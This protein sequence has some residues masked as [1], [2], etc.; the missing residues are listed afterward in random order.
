MQ[1]KPD[2]PLQKLKLINI[3]LIHNYTD[4]RFFKK[5]EEIVSSSHYGDVLYRVLGRSLK[6]W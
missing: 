5:I 1:H 3:S 4:I 6:L 2:V